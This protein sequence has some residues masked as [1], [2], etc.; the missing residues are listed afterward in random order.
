MM[1]KITHKDL[2]YHYIP[3]ISS[4]SLR[5]VAVSL[6]KGVIFESADFDWQ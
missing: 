4:E 5:E 2:F 3:I 1:S 6:N